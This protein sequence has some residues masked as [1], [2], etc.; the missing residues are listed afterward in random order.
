MGYREKREERKESKERIS[1][2]PTPALQWTTIGD[3]GEGLAAAEFLG[4]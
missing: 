2:L 1:N 4:R 3:S